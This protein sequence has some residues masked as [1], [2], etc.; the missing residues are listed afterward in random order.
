MVSTFNEIS[1][2]HEPILTQGSCV[3][4]MPCAAKIV[5]DAILY[6]E[7]ERYYLSAW[8]IMPNH[9]HVIAAPINGFNLSQITHSWKSFTANKINRLLNKTGSFW[10][11]ESFDHLIR[12]Y[13]DWIKSIEYIKENP[14]KAGLCSDSRDWFFSS[15]GIGFQASSELEF[16]DPRSTPFVHI[17]SRGELP[18]LEKP[19]G[20]YFITFRLAD[21]RV[22][23]PK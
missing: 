4:K 12:S 20:I 5:Q 6:F 15:C 3:L 19:C 7:G 23:R 1:K 8:C 11:R 10:D 18:H 16:I 21:A 22:I 14:V 2:E 13:D 9:V 17:R